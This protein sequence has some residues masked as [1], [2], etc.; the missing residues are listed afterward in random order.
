[1]V[2]TAAGL[3]ATASEN[4]NAAEH[5]FERGIAHAE[6]IGHRFALPGAR[7]SY[8]EMLIARSAPGDSE[9]ASSLLRHA[10][11]EY[12]SMGMILMLER[13]HLQGFC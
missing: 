8:A 1:M 6:R 3:A 13:A 5:H 12:R 10:M 7:Q 4:W 11:D 2:D 9:R